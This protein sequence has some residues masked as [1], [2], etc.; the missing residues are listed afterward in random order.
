MQGREVSDEVMTV[1]IERGMADVD[2]TAEGLEIGRSNRVADTVLAGTAIDGVIEQHDAGGAIRRGGH[3]GLERGLAAVVADV[4]P[5][6]RADGNSVR[7][8][9]VDREPAAIHARRRIG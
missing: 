8:T 6:C 3:V 7:I 2:R 1:V 9:W 4:E 5:V